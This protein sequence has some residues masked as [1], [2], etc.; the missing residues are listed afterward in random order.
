MPTKKVIELSPELRKELAARKAERQ[1][2]K[3]EARRRKS[4]K[5]QRER[6]KQKLSYILKKN[7][8]RIEDITY[9]RYKGRETL[10]SCNHQLKLLKTLPNTHTDTDKLMS[11]WYKS[12]PTTRPF[13]FHPRYRDVAHLF[14]PV[15]DR[16]PSYGLYWA[17]NHGFAKVGQVAYPGFF[18]D[19]ETGIQGITPAH[20]ANREQ[21]YIQLYGHLIEVERLVFLL[22]FRFLP[23][24]ITRSTEYTALEWGHFY[25]W[26]H[27][28]QPSA[29]RYKLTDSRIY[30]PGN[31]FKWPRGIKEVFETSH[32]KWTGKVS[33]RCYNRDFDHAED[34]IEYFRMARWEKYAVNHGM[35][36]R[37]VSRLKQQREYQI[38]KSR[39]DIET[40][41]Q[42]EQQVFNQ[43][44]AVH[45]DAWF[46]DD[47]NASE[48]QSSEQQTIILPPYWL[49]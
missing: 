28:I 10:L 23:T 37:E 46:R 6:A 22:R 8:R 15:D 19:N 32:R 45:K 13:Q 3:E 47:I 16:T 2:E 9:R 29:K 36:M 31:T 26:D 44:P 17:Q 38:E 30:Q 41:Q 43:G 11:D 42:A 20:K 24:Q 18:D 39:E 21:R 35:S 33:F 27:A 34:A 40:W 14:K 25:V 12:D 7:A 1:R 48:R 5:Y 4:V 49:K